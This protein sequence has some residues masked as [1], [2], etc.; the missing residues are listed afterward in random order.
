M[1]EILDVM[2][3]DMAHGIGMWHTEDCWTASKSN[4]EGTMEVDGF[5]DSGHMR[6]G[7]PFEVDGTPVRTFQDYIVLKCDTCGSVR[8][9]RDGKPY[10]MHDTG[11]GGR[12]IHFDR[13]DTGV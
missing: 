12:Q 6:Q 1:R 4:C 5:D 7:P 11:D 13:N 8:L 2:L 9:Q 10:Y 3:H